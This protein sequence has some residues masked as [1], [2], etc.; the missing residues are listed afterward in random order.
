MKCLELDHY[1]LAQLINAGKTALANKLKYLAAIEFLSA[2]LSAEQSEYVFEKSP[3]VFDK[4][5]SSELPMANDL[6][7][8]LNEQNINPDSLIIIDIELNKLMSKRASESLPDEVYREFIS[9]HQLELM[10][11]KCEDAKDCETPFMSSLEL[12]DYQ[13][14]QLINSGKTAL[15]DKL[16]YLAAIEFLSANISV[17]QRKNV[18][19]KSP[20]VFDKK[21]ASELPVAT[22][23]LQALNEQNINPDGLII[24]DT[25]L[26]KQM[27]KRASESLPDDVYREF[28]SSHQLNLMP[29]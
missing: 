11:L 13:L 10:L 8:S 23:L 2:N 17:E 18:F 14:V 29:L 9:S 21:I 4:K 20:I 26:N 7:Q 22:D 16:Q 6:L 28:I 24:I 25:E 27:S 12:D 15:V 19:E 5:L 1:Q 3:I